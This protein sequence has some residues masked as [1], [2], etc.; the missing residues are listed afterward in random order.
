MR[1]SDQDLRIEY[2]RVMQFIELTDQAAWD[3]Y[4][5]T[6]PQ[7]HPLQLWGWGEAKRTNNWRPHRLVLQAGTEWA[8]AV[9]VLL[10][11][12][13]RTGRMVAYVPRGPVV[14]PTNPAMAL[15]LREL[16]AWAR[17]HRALY[18]RLEPAWTEAKLPRGWIPASHRLQLPAT[19]TLDLTKTAQE[20]QTPMARKH[21]QYIRKAERD[22]V[23]VGRETADSVAA[24]YDIYTQTA[25]RAGFGIHTRDYYEQLFSELGEHNYLYG[26]RYE[27]QMVAF[28][29]LAAA[30]R[31]AYELYGGVT[32][33]GQELKA[34]Y[35][36]KW[37][38]IMGLQAAGYEVYDFNGRLNEGVARFKEGFGP[39]ETGYIGTWDYPLNPLGYRLWEQ[40]WPVAK[41]VGRRWAE[42]RRRG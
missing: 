36:L 16:V 28:L 20:L 9:Q 26:A 40:L 21:R 41:M 34:N 24:M 39:D 5:A 38:A 33:Q 8:A 2:N 18:V 12:I 31:T 19:Y 37:Q 17:W 3:A 4:V 30:G 29:W 22:G 14:D 35:A 11:P 42:R 6:H 25:A 32:A 23:T 7:G 27:G 10:W 15:L 13:P 1:Y